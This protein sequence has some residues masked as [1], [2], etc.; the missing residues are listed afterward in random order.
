MPVPVPDHDAWFP[1][2]GR[3]PVP[4]WDAVHAWVE[5]H[6]GE[7]EEDL[8]EAWEKI[9]WFWFS[10]IQAALGNEYLARESDHFVL[11]ARTPQAGAEAAL[12]LLEDTLGQV[13]H[14]LGSLA[15]PD[16]EGPLAVFT[17]DD[18]DLL[19]EYVGTFYDHPEQYILESGLL[20]E[21]GFPHL[22]LPSAEGEAVEGALARELAHY[23]LSHLKDIPVWLDEGL[24]Q[25]VE[26]EVAA[27]VSP[28]MDDKQLGEHRSFWDRATIQGFW[29]G[30][31][32]RQP[33]R[34]CALSY[35]L[36]YAIVHHLLHELGADPKALE[37]FV[38]AASLRD[39]GEEAARA[40]LG[41]GIG[42]L[43]AAVLGHDEPYWKPNPKTWT[44]IARAD[45][46]G[47]GH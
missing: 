40:Y 4:D 26:D 33:G 22:V 30:E 41:A 14:L 27:T 16:D 18:P 5:A 17:I 35:E 7:H 37:S 8:N 20:L 25:W 11:L 46:N 19:K 6:V 32:F 1:K 13:D 38:R 31:S 24:S 44:G 39:G 23:L 29:Q 36:S 45:R 34:I 9:W 42:T 47:Y 10:R 15:N 21:E 12:Q 43:A 3:F 2:P 28:D